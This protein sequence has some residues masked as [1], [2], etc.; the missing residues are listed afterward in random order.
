MKSIVSTA[1][2]F[3]ALNVLPAAAEDEINLPMDTR[4][5]VSTNNNGAQVTSTTQQLNGVCLYESRAYS[6]DAYVCTVG[7]HM[8]RCMPGDQ[9]MPPHW[10][11]LENAGNVCP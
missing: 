4:V 11:P 6:V 9:N 7:S 3:A 8:Q 2:I 5:A 1:V 10:G